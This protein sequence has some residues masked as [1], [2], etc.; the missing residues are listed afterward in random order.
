MAMHDRLKTDRITLVVLDRA[1]WKPTK[2]IKRQLTSF[3]E[4]ADDNHN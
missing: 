1:Q 2:V 4:H 3:L